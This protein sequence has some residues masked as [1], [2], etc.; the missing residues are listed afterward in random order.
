[1]LCHFRQF[2]NTELAIFVCVEPHGVTDKLLGARRSTPRTTLRSI[3]TTPAEALRPATTPFMGRSRAI[4]TRRK[5]LFG[6]HRQL[7]FAGN[8]VFVGISSS[9]KTSH[10]ARKLILA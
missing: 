9:Q 1:M 2:L 7:G 4:I 3:R 10:A 6:Q 8:T 5:F